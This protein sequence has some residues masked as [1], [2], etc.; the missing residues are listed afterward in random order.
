MS[1]SVPILTCSQAHS[2]NAGLRTSVRADPKGPA[3]APIR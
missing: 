1:C 2:A 3:G